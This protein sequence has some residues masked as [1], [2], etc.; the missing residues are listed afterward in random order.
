MEPSRAVQPAPT[1]AGPEAKLASEQ[2]TLTLRNVRP[3]IVM[4]P[5]F[6][7]IACAIFT[8]WVPTVDL[9][10]WFSLVVMGALVQAGMAALFFKADPPPAEIRKWLLLCAA[11]FLAFAASWASMGIFLW[12]RHDILNNTVVLLLLG[13]TLAGSAAVSSASL[14]LG[15]VSFATYGTVLIVL[16]LRE[17][18]IYDGIAAMA[19]F[20]V[21]YMAYVSRSIRATTRDMLLLRDDKNGLIEALACSKVE[22]DEARERAEAACLAKS[23]FLANMSHELRTPLN[24]ILG[25]SEMIHTG[26][27]AFSPERHI[28][29]AR[30]IHDSGQH[31]LALIDDILDLAKIEAGRLQLHEQAFDLEDVIDENLR[32]AGAIASAAR[33]RLARSVPPDLPQLYADQRAIKQILFNL[34]SNAMKF[35]PPGGTVRVFAYCDDDDGAVRFG[36]SDTGIGI[37]PEDQ[38]RVFEKF[39]QGRHDV[40]TAHKGTG[41]GLA[42]VKG[43]VS[44]HGATIALESDIGTGTCVTVTMPPSRSLVR[45][46]TA[47]AS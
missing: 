16:P 36:V 30:L 35:T 44:A 24:A 28:E 46:A 38:A 42:I 18:G 45:R 20:Y 33:I 10:T 32:L 25:F 11:A 34:L 6:A 2:L 21:A 47:V 26:T 5:L 4:M 41:L 39:G 7:A 22:S 19:L 31:L 12:V 29:Y 23:Q 40:V 1:R 13:C 37:A 43:L 14:P 15:I 17:G 3:N 27:L 8:R 9:V